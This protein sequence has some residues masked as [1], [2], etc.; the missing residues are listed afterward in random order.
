[1]KKCVNDISYHS[2]WKLTTEEP[3]K[4]S[5]IAK[6]EKLPQLKE[7]LN[8]DSGEK[9]GVENVEMSD[10]KESENQQDIVETQSHD[11]QMDNAAGTG[12]NPTP[13]SSPSNTDME[14]DSK[15]GDLQKDSSLKGGTSEKE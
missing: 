6:L 5:E 10:E 1:M 7:I 14:D 8:S 2:V 15:T 12:E 3:V 11:N 9:D 13:P 4:L